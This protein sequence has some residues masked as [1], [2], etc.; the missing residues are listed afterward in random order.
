MKKLS[1]IILTLIALI[2]PTHN[3]ISAQQVTGPKGS[4][5]GV[6]NIQGME[7]KIVFHIKNGDNGYT[8]DMDSPDQNAFGITVTSVN[9]EN[10][11]L[12]LTIA[13]AMIEY[14]AVFTGDRLMGTF[15]QGGLSIPL[16]MSRRAFES[17]KRPQEPQKPF[18]YKSEDVLIVNRVDSIVLAG[19]LT[20][21]LSDPVKAAVILISGSGIQNRDSEIMG[22]KPFLVLSD[23]LTKNGVAVL[24]YDDRGAGMSGGNPAIATT[25]DFATDARA[26]LQYLRERE[27]LT[28]VKIGM[29]GHSEGGII[30]PMI[31]S[32]G[33]YAD[34][35][36]L[37]AAPAMK[38]SEIILKQQR[39]IASGSGVG[40]QELDEYEKT[41]RGMFLLIENNRDN[42]ML[43]EIVTDFIRKSVP[44]ESESVI[45]SQ[46]R[47]VV[48]PWM[49]EFLLYDPLT[50]IQRSNI[51]ALAINGTKDLQ[52]PVENLEIIGD[53]YGSKEK[54]KI[55]KV[56]GVNHL[57]QRSSTGLP[58]EYSKI[59][60]TFS[61]SVIKIILD[62]IDTL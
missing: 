37:L 5:Y 6:L 34:F 26:A 36:V 4:W 16:N 61:E 31:A 62:W 42:P 59:E 44:G 24:R 60:E 29:I 33:N 56:D 41:S 40:E 32:E 51:P 43:F 19:T 27:E 53:N 48:N 2:N 46:A 18:P 35:M 13:G 47:T 11:M 10:S 38:G 58:S 7:L 3:K 52:V 23:Y 21:P 54:I 20:L 25:R 15:K 49:I 30:A 14:T 9:Y 12:R 55:V 50:A 8:A 39:L 45:K 28:K 1:F 57:F 17:S 22:H